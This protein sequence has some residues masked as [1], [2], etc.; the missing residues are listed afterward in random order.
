MPSSR[1]VFG[2]SAGEW[3]SEDEY[4][5]GE[6]ADYDP[7]LEGVDLEDRAKWIERYHEELTWLWDSLKERGVETF[8]KAWLQNANYG[9]FCYFAYKYTTP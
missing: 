6:D 2:D 3:S 4:D 8:G 7:E 1:D 9:T 5:S